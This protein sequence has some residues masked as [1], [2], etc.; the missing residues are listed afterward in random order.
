MDKTYAGRKFAVALALDAFADDTGIAVAI[1][2]QRL[3]APDGPV[4]SE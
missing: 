4:Q 1:Q 2:C 3:F